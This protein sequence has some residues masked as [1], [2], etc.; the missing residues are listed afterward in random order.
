MIGFFDLVHL[1]I[2]YPKGLIA[3]YLKK[4][5]KKPYTI[6]E[7]WTGYQ[8]P[9]N[10]SIGFFK[11]LITKSII[12]NAS[13]VCPVSNNLAAEMKK[14]GL[15]GNYHVIPNIVN[16]NLFLPKPSVSDTFK[17][18][19]VSSMRDEQKNVSGIIKTVSNLQDIIHNFELV[20]IGD[21]S[22][23]YEGLAKKLNLN[24][25]TFIDQISQKELIEHFH[26]AHLFILFSNHENLPCVILESFST[27]TPVI[28]SN[29]GGVSE[30]FPNN[31]GK[32]IP[33][34]DLGKLEI[35]ILN[36]YNSESKYAAPSEMHKYAV[37]NFSQKTIC[38][39]YT[40][41]YLKMIE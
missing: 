38:E 36:F 30:F 5:K 19:H 8:Y 21:K 15:K 11:K 29:V 12:K 20:L 4:F 41:Q 1:N 34:N 32:I 40:N 22:N 24:N 33:K 26:D 23:R 10:K 17:I 37:D 6:T 16:T 9:L 3:L 7:H 27:G 25:I 2:T 18:L 28:S 14:F 39:K 35:E 13:F 31:F